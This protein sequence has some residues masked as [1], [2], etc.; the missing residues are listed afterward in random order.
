[1]G[2]PSRT[3]CV[4]AL[5]V[6]VSCVLERCLC[7]HLWC[8]VSYSDYSTVFIRLFARRRALTMVQ[9]PLSPVS[10]SHRQPFVTS[11]FAPMRI[12]MRRA[13]SNASHIYVG[14]YTSCDF[15]HSDSLLPH[16]RTPSGSNL[17]RISGSSTGL[18]TASIDAS[19]CF[20]WLYTRQTMCINIVRLLTMSG[21]CIFRHSRL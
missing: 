17:P 16:I 3:E 9:G 20:A 14:A 2:I 18:S 19:L 1:M 10:R 13:H 21:F 11:M 15:S 8:G 5:S 6:R 4:T 12:R 7:A